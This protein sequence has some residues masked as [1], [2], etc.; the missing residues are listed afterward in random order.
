VILVAKGSTLKVFLAWFEVMLVVLVVSR[1]QVAIAESAPEQYVLEYPAA[2]QFCPPIAGYFD[3][4]QRTISRAGYRTFRHQP[5]GGFGLPV[6]DRVGEKHLLHLGAD[7]G[8]HRVGEPVFAVADGVVRVSQGAADEGPRR[9]GPSQ[10][11][12]YPSHIAAKTPHDH[13]GDGARDSP[14]PYREPKPAAAL[15]WGNLIVLEHRLADGEYVTTVYGHLANDRLVKA[16][17]V[18]RAGQQIGAIGTARV[19][20]G[21]KPHLHFGVR[22]GRMAEV[23]RV[24]VQLT[25]N[26]KLAPLRIA[27]LHEDVVVFDGIEGLPERMHLTINTSGIKTAQRSGQAQFSPKAPETEPV[28]GGFKFEIRRDGD[29]AEATSAI[30]HFVQPPEFAI[31]GYGLSAKSWRDP[32]AFLKE[33]R[34]DIMPAA[35]ELPKPRRNLLK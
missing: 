7:V 8:W 23:G 31:V 28:P 11:G 22:E 14:R 9:R 20:G 21:Y 27:E 26:G 24:L 6:Q 4:V 17:D 2:E 16:G 1:P 33:H 13:R 25:I 5:N 10:S 3:E 30:L 18:V 35:F 29:R 15:A 32:T 12:W 34:A 19:N